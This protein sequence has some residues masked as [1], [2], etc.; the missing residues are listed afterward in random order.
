MD[1]ILE[2]ASSTNEIAG[3]GVEAVGLIGS[4]L[5]NGVGSGGSERVRESRSCGE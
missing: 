2:L 5:G 1:S 3:N 4:G